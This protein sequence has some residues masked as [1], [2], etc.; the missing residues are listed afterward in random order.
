MTPRGC[1]CRKRVVGPRLQQLS[2]GF[3]CVCF[4]KDGSWRPVVVDDY[5]PT[6]WMGNHLFA[7]SRGNELWVSVLEKA[8]ASLHG[9]Y[10][11]IEGGWIEDALCDLTGELPR[12]A[13]ARPSPNPPPPLT[14]VI[15]R[16]SPRC[17][18]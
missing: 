13:V 1:R 2:A 12:R 4:Y 8:Y 15:V 17:S 18:A 10:T 16:A 3:F 9:S 11:A 6:N 14:C 5:L 7:R